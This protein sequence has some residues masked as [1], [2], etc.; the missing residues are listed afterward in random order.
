MIPWGYLIMYV[1]RK[2]KLIIGVSLLII[3]CLVAG[4]AYIYIEYY[5]TKK[6]TTTQQP[7]TPIVDD[8]ISPY[9]KQGLILEVNRI[10]D[11]GIVDALMA[12]GNSWKTLPQFYYIANIDNV[13]QISKDISATAGAKSEQLFVTWD[14]MFMENKMIADVPN[15]QE[16]S[17][18]SLA[19]MERMPV[20]LLGRRY[21]DVEQEKIQVTYN[22]KTGR[23]TGD[24]AWNDTDGYQHFCGKNFEVWFNLYQTDND[25]DYIPYWTEVNVLHTDPNV[26]DLNLDPD[27]DGIPTTWE[28]RWGYDPHV[29]NNHTSLDPDHDGLTNV[30]EY[31]MEKYFANPYY[32]DVYLE[33]DNMQ[34][35]NIFDVK[36]ELFPDTPEFMEE[37]YA[38]HNICLYID[39]GWP[40][41]PANGGGQYVPY[42]TVIS[43]DSGMM[44]QFYD[45]YFPDD[46]KGIFRY[47]IIANSAGFDHPSKFNMYDSMAISTHYNLQFSL[48]RKA[49]T[50]RTK[51]LAQASEIMHE[52]GH[53]MGIRHETV[54]GNDNFSYT[55]GKA[56]KQAFLDKWGNYKSSMN[57]YYFWDYS[58]ID[59]SDGSHGT[60]DNND[61]AM[62]KQNMSYFK[63][64]A[65]E[66]EQPPPVEQTAVN[67]FIPRMSIYADIP[68]RPTFLSAITPGK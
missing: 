22:Y 17:D 63:H 56:Q 19:I 12:K 20:G 38:Q 4:S 13:E 8:R 36:H 3:A 58:V 66:I 2:Q 59:Y 64:E 44:L 53:S 23:W 26:S 42:Y 6:E 48:L 33:I 15:E 10:R 65:K 37:R 51:I 57:Y 61:W 30:E 7:A 1:K 45:H 34:Q 9:C 32:Q 67:A 25:H 62:I 24:D 60:G 54:P 39:N 18:V 31:Q 16:R 21:Q 28:W 27:H 43:Q 55:E 52:L 46:R 29:W 49:F 50:Q 47:A 14:T 40:D 41:S 11:R 35:Q 68:P 5:A